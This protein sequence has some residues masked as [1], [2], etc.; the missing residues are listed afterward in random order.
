MNAVQ[1]IL[2]QLTNLAT[3]YGLKLLISIA[4]FVIGRWL[5]KFFSQLLKKAMG[6]THTDATLTKFLTDL[7]Y[8]ALLTA[9]GIAALSNLGIPMTSFLAVLG[10]A[11]LAVGLALQGSLSNFAAGVLLVFFR[12]YKVGDLVTVAGSTGTVEE[13]QIFNS[14]LATPDHKTIIIPNSQALSGT[15]TNFSQKGILV[16]DMRFAIGHTADFPKAKALLLNI[17]AE[18]PTTLAGTTPTVNVMEITPTAVIFAAR[19]TVKASDYWNSWFGVHEQV[20]L[21][22]ADAGIPGPEPLVQIA[23]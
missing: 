14:V 19:T 20:K 2:A 8:Y 5:S 23:K 1:L 3:L 17:L 16:V 12:P 9:V 10:A 11:G 4:I 15:I 22:F 6:R 18:E 13:I 21:R 7:L